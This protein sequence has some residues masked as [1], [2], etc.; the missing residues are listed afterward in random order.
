MPFYAKQID[1]FFHQGKQMKDV[2][3]IRYMQV[4]KVS[5]LDSHSSGIIL[6]V[7]KQESK[8]TQ[9]VIYSIFFH[10]TDIDYKI[11]T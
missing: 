1:F 5:L 10:I 2:K 6:R 4:I 3:H 7:Y 8:E 11:K 9:T